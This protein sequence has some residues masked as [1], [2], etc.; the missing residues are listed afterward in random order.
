MTFLQINLNHCFA[1]QKVMHQTAIELTVDVI[2]V[3][4]QLTNS[5]NDEFW[6]CSTEGKS[7]VFLTRTSS[8]VPESRGRGTGFV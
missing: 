5:A 6:T 7:T 4:D 8:L 3:S 2:L 1:A